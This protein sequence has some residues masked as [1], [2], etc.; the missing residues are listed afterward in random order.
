MGASASRNSLK[1]GFCF[2]PAIRGFAP[3]ASQ[4]R[5]TPLCGPLAALGSGRSGII[6]FYR[7]PKA[8]KQFLLSGVTRD[9]TGV[10]LGGVTV[11][12][13]TELDKT[14]IA[15][16]VSDATTGT[17]SFSVPSNGWPLFLRIYKTGSPDVA[18]TS[19]NGLYA[20]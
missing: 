4:G 11:D 18:G 20:S 8:N 5:P 17:Y 12:L 16:T 13:Y 19:V 10:I 15:S 2:I 9:N 14:C 3:G 7:V 6:R 1:G